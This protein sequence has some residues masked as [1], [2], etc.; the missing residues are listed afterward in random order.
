MYHFK[1]L[2]LNFWILTNKQLNIYRVVDL[3][4]GFFDVVMQGV[5]AVLHRYSRHI[6][7]RQSVKFEET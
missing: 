1:V 2:Y 6:T 7:G 5:S 4:G 3:T